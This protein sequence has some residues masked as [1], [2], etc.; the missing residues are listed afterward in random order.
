ME[1]EK[2]KGKKNI[3]YNIAAFTEFVK[4]KKRSLDSVSEDEWVECFS[5]PRVK[6]RSDYLRTLDIWGRYY[7]E[8][9]IFTGFFDDIIDNPAGL[10]MGI[11][12]FLGVD[13]S[14]RHLPP[15]LKKAVNAGYKSSIPTQWEE[16][17]VQQYSDQII[18]VY[19][20]LGGR[21]SGWLARIDNWA[22]R[23]G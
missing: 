21:S 20:R 18:Q 19:E 22:N 5:N 8:E 16:Y 7:P 15:N 11:Y 6:D 17:L 13:A 12:R 1:H 3:A 2:S 23:R 10:L 9:Q 14:E 4:H